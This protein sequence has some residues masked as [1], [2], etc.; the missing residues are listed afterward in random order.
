M[1]Q[2]LDVFKLRTQLHNLPFMQKKK[3]P[4][5]D[6]RVEIKVTGELYDKEK[7]ILEGDY[8]QARLK[9]KLEDGEE[10]L[11]YATQLIEK[12][13]TPENI[14]WDEARY[15]Y[16]LTVTDADLIPLVEEKKEEMEKKKLKKKLKEAISKWEKDFEYIY[17][18]SGDLA[19]KLIDKYGLKAEEHL[20]ELYEELKKMEEERKEEAIK[21][22]LKKLKERWEEC[23]KDRSRYEDKLREY[24]YRL[25][26]L[27]EYLTESGMLA[28]FK[29]WIEEQEEKED[30]GD[31]ADEFFS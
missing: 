15:E 8:N 16:V 26:M 11:V 10:F 9:V 17:I 1:A 21:E 2:V 12:Y 28:E 29:E 30:V 31:W 27:R 5:G 14:R 25:D 22:E 24:R 20:Q 6:Y 18:F 4:A 19:E 7:A 13:A 23:R 3:I